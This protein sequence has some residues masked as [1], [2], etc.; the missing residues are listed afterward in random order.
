[1]AFT[2]TQYKNSAENAIDQMVVDQFRRSNWLL[3]RMPF[4]D[5]AHPFGQ[6][7]WVYQYDRLTTEPTAAVRA[8]NAEYSAQQA[9]TTAQTVELKIFGGS[10]EMD[11]TQIGT[12]RYGDRIAFQLEQKIKA[13]RA[14]FNDLF[15]NGDT[16]TSA[17]EFDG[18]DTALTNGTTDV[19]ATSAAN[20]LSTSS[21]MD[22]NY[23][24]FLDEF[25]DW[26]ATLDRMPDALF[27]NRT[28]HSRM[29]AIAHRAG[30]YSQTEDAFGRPV[31]TFDGI[32]FIDL[33]DKPGTSNPVVPIT[34]DSSGLDTTNIY[35]AAFGLDA[36]H[37]I[38]PSTQSAFLQTY[39]PNLDLPG[40]VKTGEVEMVAAIAVKH[41]K[42]A[43]VF[44]GIGVNP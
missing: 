13:T 18:L 17:L 43:G 12:A 29:R 28:M 11:R 37:G 35:A 32:P 19:T 22:S 21:T 1:M 4:D 26:L 30:Y 39:L 24:A 6:S 33:G 44:R 8:V 2:L 3:D 27:M 14:Y 34:A 20:D 38:S 25:Y 15:I 7:G 42:A 23:K 41:Q 9:V 31:S 5:G 16:G 40:A 36:V 10:F